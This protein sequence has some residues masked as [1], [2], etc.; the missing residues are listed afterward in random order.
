MLKKMILVAVIG[1]VAVAAFQGTKWAS[2]VRQEIASLREDAESRIPPEREIARLRGELKLLDNDIMK[3][4]NQLAKEKVEVT[5]L[6]KQVDDLRVSQSKNKELLNARA[7]AIKLAEAKVKAGEA[8]VFVLFGDRRVALPAA[9]GELEDG[10]RIYS[11]NQ[12]SLD[13]MTA[14]LDSR[15]KIKDGLEKQLEALKNQ[16]AELAT[17][18]DALEAELT[19]L[20]LKQME[21]KYQTDNTRLAKIKEDMRSLQKKIAIEREKLKL[22]PGVH[23]GTGEASGKSVDDIMAPL[24]G[25]PGA[26]AKTEGGMPKATD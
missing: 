2:Y 8:D 1:G 10:V 23:E 11:T 7:E 5:D 17:A 24:N 14:T 19:M 20:K 21:S 9:K 15:E 4:V 26:A 12:R 22:M 25:K 3:V 16:K 13:A 18:I 6:R